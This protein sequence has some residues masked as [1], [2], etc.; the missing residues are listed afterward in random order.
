MFLR[1][2]LELAESGR[3][4]ESPNPL[5]GAVLVR[6]GETIGE[7]FHARLGAAHAEVAT[8]EDCRA[9]GAD[10]AGATLY[11]TLEPCAHHGRR[12]P[13]TDAIVGAGVARVVVGSD[14]PSEKASGRGPGVLRDVG[15]E[16]TFADGP[17]ATAARLLNQG[18][19]KHARTGRPHVVLKS[20]LSLDGRVAAASGDSRWI[21]GES[22]RAMVHRWRAE[23]DAVVVGIGTALADDPLL[24][25]R[26]DE[27]STQPRRVVFDSGGRL[28]LDSTLVE[29]IADAPLAVVVSPAAPADRVEALRAAG[30]EPIVVGGSRADAVRGALAELGRGEVTTLLLEGGPTLAGAFLEAGEVDELRLFFAP[31]VLG[32]GPSLIE[33]GG[34]ERVADAARALSVSWEQVG[35]DLLATA[36]LREW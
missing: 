18:F 6:D 1:R 10:P 23:A 14:D 19:R 9:R 22:S 34:G 5:V 32:A 33:G 13:C 24:T 35:D 16:I 31:L 8:L 21:S 12:P 29:S 36:R 17:E 15:V 27:V 2:A 4:S 3:G 25:A 11:V 30:A 28:P 20:A 26:A 7:G